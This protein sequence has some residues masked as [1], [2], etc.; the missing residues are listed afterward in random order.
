MELDGIKV[1]TA[2]EMKDIENRAFQ[3]GCSE[4][5]F[6]QQ[7]GISVAMQVEKFTQ[8]RKLPKEV[9]LF[10][11]RGNN[12]GDGF[13]AGAILV[14]KGYSVIAY[15]IYPVE[16][17]SALC[18][19]MYENFCSQ[20]G[21]IEF[22]LEK[23][24]ERM[25]HAGLILDALV[26]TGMKKSA[27]NELAAAIEIANRSKLPILAID[28]PSGLN[29]TT[30]EVGL[31]AIH[32]TKTIYLELAKTGFFL[33]DGWDHVGEI[34]RGGFGLPEDQ[35]KASACLLNLSSLKLP[36]IQRSWHKYQKGYVVAIAGSEEMPGAAVL[37]SYAA[38]RS[39][40]GIVRVFSPDKI[41]VPY[42]MMHQT[43][44]DK[45]F[46][47]LDQEI[48]RAKAVLVGPGLGRVKKT[49]K[50]VQHLLKFNKP[51]VIDADALFS[52]ATHSSWKLPPSC[53]LT[54]HKQ[55]MKRLLESD[56]TQEIDWLFL[57]QNYVDEKQV[58]LVLKGAPTFIFTCGHLPLIITQGDPALATAGSGD[59]LTGVIAALLCHRLTSRYAAALGCFI[60]AVAGKK[61]AEDLTSYSVIASDL[62]KY[63]PK[64]LS[65]MKK[66]DYL[67][68]L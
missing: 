37:A 21:K 17:F 9:L 10:A 31:I 41:L 59:V 52:L 3:K 34:V 60:H 36:L 25:S 53:I 40:A 2:Q 47:A 58:T 5:G 18:R 57:C 30:G 51:L 44:D 7:A 33:R 6:M 27:D 56:T 20:G 54:P 49:D 65:L 13:A 32:A 67:Q 28:I 29:G 46:D 24:Q 68:K 16:R 61:A 4:L 64:A 1:V 22:S 14:A 8:E 45:N 11:G 66:A 12:A 62:V 43:L 42:E 48:A 23:I 38:L 26:G 63:L 39:G 55:E 35:V 15:P 50:I 19:N